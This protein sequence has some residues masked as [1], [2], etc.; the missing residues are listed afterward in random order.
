[1]AAIQEPSSTTKVSSVRDGR[2]RDGDGRGSQLG[3][4]ELTLA[5]GGQRPRLFQ[6]VNRKPQLRVQGGKND[7]ENNNLNEIDS[8]DRK[9]VAKAVK[10][11]VWG[12]AAYRWREGVNRRLR[13]ER[14]REGWSLLM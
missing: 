4:G 2:R 9:V 3:V 8:G 14:R 11:E 6:A 13:E 7:E 5:A 1:M 10:H 12:F